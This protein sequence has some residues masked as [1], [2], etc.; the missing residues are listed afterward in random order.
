MTALRIQ[1]CTWATT[2]DPPFCTR[3]SQRIHPFALVTHKIQE[4]DWSPINN[5]GTDQR[6]PLHKLTLYNTASH[7]FSVILIIGNPNPLLAKEVQNRKAKKK[8]KKKMPKAKQKSSS[9][10]CRGGYSPTWSN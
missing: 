6:I 8:K 3:H 4:F 9:R 10:G 2:E 7:G 5:S 1:L